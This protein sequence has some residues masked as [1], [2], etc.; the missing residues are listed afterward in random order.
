MASVKPVL[1]TGSPRSGTTWVGKMLSESE[2]LYYVHEPFNPNYPPGS[3]IC[4]VRFSH[5]QTYVTDDNEVAYY[6][7]IRDMIEG[8][9]NLRAALGDVKSLQD[10]RKALAGQRRLR[11]YRRQG[12]SPLIKDPIALMSAGWLGR[13]FDINVV[14]M[15]RHPAAFAASMKRLN[16][17]FDPSLWALSQPMLLRD[18][19]SPFE[20]ELQG[21]LS[22]RAGIVEQAAMLWKIAY[23]VV[24]KYQMKFPDWIFLRHE[25]LARDPLAGYK[26]LFGAL[27]LRFTDEARDKIVESS[28]ESNP[29]HASGADRLLRLNSKAVISQWHEALT[30]DEIQRIR[31]IVGD[32]AER[33]YT[34]D[35]WYTDPT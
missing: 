7:P 23:F 11:E 31:D 1:V 3:G 32:V 4:N 2:E 22:S 21:L 28:S 12:M 29:I 30:A 9:Y 26:R 35:D 20:P 17:G 10:V 13:R 6:R 16:W 27:G 18:Y 8:K 25:D 5:H 34:S 19:L 14:V 33:F 24:W 15:I